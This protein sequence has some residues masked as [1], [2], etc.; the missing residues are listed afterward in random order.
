MKISSF[1]EYINESTMDDL[2][3]YLLK[4]F[5]KTKFR[6]TEKRTYKSIVM[7]LNKN[8]NDIKYQHSFDNN[9][10]SVITSAKIKYVD[11]VIII[12]SFYDRD[13]KEYKV[14]MTIN[15]NEENLP[16]SKN[17]SKKIFSILYKLYSKSIFK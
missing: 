9:L 17:L 6:L 8:S 3:Y 7:L 13:E 12:K 10:K 4:S 1:E 2:K 11:S 14:Y 16:F 15:N 5:N